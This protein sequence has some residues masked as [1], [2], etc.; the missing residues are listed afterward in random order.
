MIEQIKEIL[1]PNILKPSKIFQQTIRVVVEELN[2]I[3]T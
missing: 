3:K 2:G 1:V